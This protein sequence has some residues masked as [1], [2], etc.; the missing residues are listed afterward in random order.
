MKTLLSFLCMSSLAHGH[1]FKTCDINDVTRELAQHGPQDIIFLDVDDTLQ[2]IKARM[3][4]VAKDQNSSEG[5]RFIDQMKKDRAKIPHFEERISQWRMSRKAQ[6]VDPQW[7]HLI[8]G[9]K[10]KGISVYGLTQMDTGPSGS[11]KRIEDW[12]YNELNTLGIHF[13]P[14]YEGVKDRVVFRG[15]SKPSQAGLVTPAMFYHGIFMTG[16]FSKGEIVRFVL[17]QKKPK[18]I[19]LVDDRESH[20]RDV[21]KVCQTY[22]VP[23]TG[24]VFRGT[25]CIQRPAM[26]DQLAQKVIEYQKKGIVEGKW[27]EDE[28]ALKQIQGEGAGQGE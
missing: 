22:G 12:R 4:S 3:F 16:A 15:Q 7:P 2:T 20:V 21:E 11:M 1:V 8:E 14:E 23:F 10:K 24:I 5:S 18:R 25:E 26:S 9:W 19:V 13:T 6:L 17:E 28:E 27:V